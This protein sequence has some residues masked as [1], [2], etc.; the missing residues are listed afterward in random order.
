MKTWIWA[1]RRDCLAVKAVGA[2][3]DGMNLIPLICMVE[4][5]IGLTHTKVVLGAGK[6]EQWV[7]V[8]AA[9]PWGLEFNHQNLGMATSF[10]NLSAEMGLETGG[11]LGFSDYQSMAKFS[12]DHSEE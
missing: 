2:R 6:M 8:L 5:E 7:R 11:P 1:G 12:K 3:P 4:D 10:Y 9:Q